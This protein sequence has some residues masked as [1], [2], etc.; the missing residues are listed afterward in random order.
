V[1]E[2]SG[3]RTRDVLAKGCILD[4]HPRVFAPGDVA[5]T[6]IAH[7]TVH[8]VQIDEAPSFELSVFRSLAGSLL[9]WLTASAEEYGALL[10]LD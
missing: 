10:R 2:I 7:M 6:M 8:L 1:L 4:L 9:H 5:L 3:P